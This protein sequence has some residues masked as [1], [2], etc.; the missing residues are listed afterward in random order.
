MSHKLEYAR[1]GDLF[2]RLFLRDTF[3]ATSWNTIVRLELVTFYGFLRDILFK[4]QT[5]ILRYST[6]RTSFE[7]V[8]FSA[9]SLWY[10]SSCK[11]KYCS[12]TVWLEL[13]T[14]F[15][16]FLKKFLYESFRETGWKYTFLVQYGSNWRPFSAFSLW[17]FSSH[18]LEYYSTARTG[19]LFSAFSLWYFSSHKLE[20][21]STAR[22]GDRLSP[23]DTFRATSWN[24]IARLE[25]AIFFGFLLVILF[26]PQ[27]GIL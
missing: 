7:L 5:G 15:G 27:A 16:F 14:Y 21:C 8:P 12:S 22:T 18:K 11:L 9:F 20:Y 23:C 1:A 19:D 13:A 24:T 4:P 26:V 17:Y 10:F 3:R 2:F 25:L 6:A